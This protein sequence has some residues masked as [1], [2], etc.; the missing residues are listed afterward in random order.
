MLLVTDDAIR[1]AATIMLAETGHLPEGAGAAG[2]AV[3]LAHPERFAGQ[4]VVILL[5]GGNF[6]PSIWEALQRTD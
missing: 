1:A 3:L 2:L 4:R 5:T 6:E